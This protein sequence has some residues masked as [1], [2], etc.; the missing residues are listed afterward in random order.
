MYLLPFLISGE[1]FHNP[2]KEESHYEFYAHV[3]YFTYNTLLKYIC[4]FGFYPE[5][6]YLGIHEASSRYQKLYSQSKYKALSFKY[7]MKT[8]YTYFSPRW[9]SEPVIC[10]KKTTQKESTHPKIRKV[11][12]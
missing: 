1:T 6:V 3:R 8:I 4:N 7:I 5:A 10:F 2:L 11:V 9:A 12:L